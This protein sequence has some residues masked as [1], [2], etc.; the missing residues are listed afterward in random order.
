M[1]DSCRRR[2]PAPTSAVGIHLHQKPGIQRYPLR[3]RPG[4][5]RRDQHHARRHAARRRRP[6]PR[7]RRLDPRHLPR[8]P[9]GPRPTHRT[10]HRLRRRHR[11]SREGR[12]QQ[13]R[14]SMARTGRRTERRPYP[15]PEPHTMSG[16]VK[17]IPMTAPQQ[18]VIVG[19]GLAG[20]KTAEALRTQGFA[21]RLTLLAAENHLP[22]ERPPL[23]K[24]YLA[25]Q[26][27]FDEA[28]VHPSQWYRDNDIDL[29]LG[30]RATAIDAAAH[31]VRLAD[32]SSIGYEKLVLATGALPRRLP[33]PGADA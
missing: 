18:I 25:G 17:E 19:G 1:A 4:R 15:E 8:R 5:T 26:A 7:P 11:Q 23:S 2:C 27:S 31:Q 9:G 24:G 29:R 6:R 20:A 32:G 30:I 33:L 13:V 3:C 10:R 12:D 22:Y 28:T 21:G 14:N 16:E